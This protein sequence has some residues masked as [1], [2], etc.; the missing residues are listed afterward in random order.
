MHE[1]EALCDT[2]SVF[3]NGRHIETFAKGARSAR[4]DRPADDRPRR[5]GP[6]PAEAG[7]PA[8]G[9]AALRPR[10]ALGGPPQRRRPRG[11]PRRDRRPRRP[12]RPGPEGAAARALR[13]AARRRGRGPRRRA[14][15]RPVLA[16]RREVRR[17]P[18]RAGPRGPQDRGPDAR[19]A[20]RRQPARRLLRPRLARPVHRRGP[21]PRR[22]R[23]G[24]REALR[25][26]IGSPRR[27]GRHA[28]RR[29]PAEGRHRQ[30]A[31]GPPRPDPAQRPDPRHRRR[32][33][34][35]ALP[36]DARASPTR[37]R[38]S[39]STRPTTPS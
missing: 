28:L 18:H 21:R 33:Q 25:I 16:R 13:R 35:G 36:P 9:A 11:R 27:P 29:Q 15:R 5:R 4:R 31:D 1:V 12:R 22:H 34:A 39:S 24:A 30:V 3:R 19:P 38:R 32:H 20:D 2:L 37:A 8:P 23:R 7:P 6:V 14:A 10:P 17:R 26:K